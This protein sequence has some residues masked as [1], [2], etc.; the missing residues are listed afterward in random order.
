MCVVVVGGVALACP[1]ASAH[2]LVVG[3][4]SVALL[5]GVTPASLPTV[6]SLSEM[7]TTICEVQEPIQI[8]TFLDSKKIIV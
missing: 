4:V 1:P 8:A 7:T 5:Q 2:D 3:V 6:V